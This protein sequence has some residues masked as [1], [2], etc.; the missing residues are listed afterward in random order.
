M[1]LEWDE[2]KRADNL[3]KHGVDFADA[4]Y[5]LSDANALTIPDHRH[6]E[7]RFVTIGAGPT[8]RPLVVVYTHRGDR[9]RIISARKANDR[10]QAKYRG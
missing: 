6:A 7:S 4:D 10:E 5:I 2:R 3:A 1:E 9:I 8:G